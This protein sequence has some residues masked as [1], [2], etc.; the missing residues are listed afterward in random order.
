M[1]LIVNNI[2]E[3]AFV[4]R[5]ESQNNKSN[6]YLRLKLKGNKENKNAIGAKILLWSNGKIQQQYQ[7]VIRGYLSSMEP[8]IHFG[9]ASSKIDSIKVIWPNKTVTKQY[10]LKANSVVTLDIK[11]AKTDKE[12]VKPSTKILQDK[13]TLLPFKHEENPGHDYVDQHLLMR[14]Y[15]KFGPCI[16]AANVDAK[17]G[18]ELFIGGSKGKPSQIWAQNSKGIFAVIQTLDAESEDTDAVFV[19]IDNDNDLDLYVASGGTE[20]PLGSKL[21]QDRIYLNNGKGHFEK[22]T[23]KLPENYEVSSCVRPNDFDKDGDVDFFVG[24]RIVTGRYPETPKSQLLIN[25]GGRFDNSK[26]QAALNL[27]MI[28]DAIWQDINKDGW[29]DLIVVGE[30]MPITIFMNHKGKLVKQATIF[31]DNSG[32]TMKTSGWWNTIAAGDFDKD[33]DIDF[34]VGNQGLN[35]FVSPKKGQTC[36]CL[37]SRF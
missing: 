24:S 3:P 31:K 36:I 21:L 13:S 8:I 2:N 7:S 16:A 9:L 32:N 5:N 6:H 15:S 17:M 27:G 29:D 28:T 30:W 33:G 20:F 14:Q 35:G 37:Q 19:D 22:A 26:D 23:N 11:T 4:I 10:K 1:D 25:N 18:D 12:T 34:I